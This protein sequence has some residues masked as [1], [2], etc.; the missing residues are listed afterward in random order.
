MET[1]EKKD[2]VEDVKALLEEITNVYGCRANLE[3]LAVGMTTMH[4]TLVQ[5]FTSGFVIPFV[6]EM[7]R[8]KAEDCFD[9]RDKLAVEVCE[10]MSN[11]IDE[12]FGLKP[13]EKVT[14][15]LI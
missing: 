5:S 14:L 13:G 9:D 10:A 3:R 1:E 15:P 6:L 2:K 8:L 12:K 4:K 7:A 11:A